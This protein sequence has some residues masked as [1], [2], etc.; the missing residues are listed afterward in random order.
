MQASKYIWEVLPD[1]SRTFAYT[2][3]KLP[4]GLDFDTALTY[5]MYRIIDTI[6][7]S[8][9]ALAKKTELMDLFFSLFESEKNLT[10]FQE[11]VKSIPKNQYSGL[12]ANAFKIVEALK[13]RPIDI[14]KTILGG[15]KKMAGGFL[16]EEVQQINTL[17]DQNIYCYYAAGLVG[18]VMNELTMHH[19]LI[20]KEKS[21]ELKEKAKGIGLAFQKVNILKDIKVDMDEDRFY[22]PKDILEMN[23]VTYLTIGKDGHMED[24]L[25]VI[26]DLTKDVKHYFD[27]GLGFINGLPHKPAGLRIFWAINLMMAIATVR[28]IRDPALFDDTI[29][30]TRLEVMAIDAAVTKCVEN[31]ESLN[32]LAH[33][34]AKS[35]ISVS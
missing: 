13:S 34:V 31:K 3:P 35:D 27:Q 32:Q 23:N 11:E 20:T 2:I 16:R 6:E 29:K 8:P 30:I 1:I 10:R 9:L 15:G 19:H 21:V 12:L 22:W 25:S 26:G 5:A 4:P 24:S 14:Q 17:E 33:A 18:E 7:D 28:V